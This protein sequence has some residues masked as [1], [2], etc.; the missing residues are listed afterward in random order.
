MADDCGDFFRAISNLCLMLFQFVD[1]LLT[2]L[3]TNAAI[4][5]PTIGNSMPRHA[6]PGARGAFV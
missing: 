5:A 3:Q 2:R 6:A 4:L 1:V